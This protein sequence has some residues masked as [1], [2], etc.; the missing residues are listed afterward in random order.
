MTELFSHHDMTLRD[1]PF[2]GYGVK[3]YPHIRERERA[4]QQRIVVKINL[5]DRQIVGGAPVVTYQYLLPICVCTWPCS[6]RRA[7]FC[8]SRMTR[9]ANGAKA[10]R[11]GTRRAATAK[12]VARWHGASPAAC[13]SMCSIEHESL[14]RNGG[15]PSARA[16][17]RGCAT[18]SPSRWVPPLDWFRI[19]SS[20]S[21]KRRSHGLAWL[22][23]AG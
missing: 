23:A 17:G 14:G 19:R 13:C 21:P 18:P 4:F 8:A 11:D 10:L 9:W 3:P 22:K 12:P 1:G 20:R 7:G 2:V 15:P 5:A 6:T 16:S